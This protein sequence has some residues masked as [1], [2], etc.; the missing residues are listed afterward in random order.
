MS[1]LYPRIMS[2][3]HK[4]VYIIVEGIHDNLVVF[5]Y[6]LCISACLVQS[7]Q[8]PSC[9]S[10]ASLLASCSRRSILPVYL[11]RLC[12]PRAVVAASFLYILCVS[13]CLVQSSQHPS[14]IFYASLL[15]SCS[16]R[17]I[18]PVYLMRLCLPRAVVAASFLY[19]LCIS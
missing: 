9:I 1:I 15:A 18:L 14:C 5:L 12:L 8:H 10:Y 2:Y 3:K 6:I 13:A 11:M 4:Q 19:V 16:R 7:S 17:S